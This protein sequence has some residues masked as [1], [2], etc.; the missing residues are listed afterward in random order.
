MFGFD[1]LSNA[2]VVR[3]NVLARLRVLLGVFGGYQ[4][5][6]NYMRGPGP[7]CEATSPEMSDEARHA[8]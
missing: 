4:P 7:A 8:S 1:R 2:P 6:R 5:N 3:M